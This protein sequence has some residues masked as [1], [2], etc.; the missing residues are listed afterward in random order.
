MRCSVCSGTAII[1]RTFCSTMLMR[2]RKA[3]SNW[4][5]RTSTEAFSLITRSRTAE[6][7]RKPSPL[8]AFT[9]RR[10]PSRIMTTPRC[11]PTPSMARSRM[12]GKRSAKVPRPASSCPA[13]ISASTCFAPCCPGRSTIVWLES[14][15][16]RLVKIVE[17]LG[18][19]DSPDSKITTPSAGRAAPPLSSKT[20]ARCPAVMRS[21]GF[22][23]SL[24]RKGMLFTRVPFLLPRSWAVQSSPSRSRTMCCRD[25]PAS[26]GKHNSAV[27]ERPTINRSPCSGTVLICPSGH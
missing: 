11:A 4:A 13:R 7:M 23:F 18:G 20:I 9:S 1:V 16:S 2:S 24:A 19:S 27:L 8:L 22:S 21:P 3:S 26:S 17:V 6:L 25:K 15:P 12:R 5:S 14:A 10:S